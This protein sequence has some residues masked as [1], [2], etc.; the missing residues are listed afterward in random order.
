MWELPQNSADS[1]S[2]KA[3]LEYRFFKLGGQIPICIRVKSNRNGR[4]G[5]FFLTLGV[6]AKI[7][8]L[9]DDIFMSVLSKAHRTPSLTKENAVKGWFVV[10]AEGKTLGR[11][12]SGIAAR[13]RGKHKA[14]FTPNQ[15]CGDNIIVINASKVKVTGNKEMQKIYYHH[16]R[17]PGGMTETVFKDLITKQPEKVIYEAVK[18]M[19]PKSK[20]GDKILTHCKIFSGA[21]HNLQA[22]KPVKL[23][24]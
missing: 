17:Y 7:W 9:Q 4:S 15:D 2:K 10:D 1:E 22:Q 13:L 23:E 19:L 14:T 5:S 20:L 8:P 11:L 16:S 3:E 21:E 18:G 12:A 24:I 6:K